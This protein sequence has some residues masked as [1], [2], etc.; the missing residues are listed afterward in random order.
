VRGRTPIFSG[1]PDG[2]VLRMVIGRGIALAVAGI[3]PARRS[4]MMPESEVRS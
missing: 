2:E 4:A 3:G 1:R